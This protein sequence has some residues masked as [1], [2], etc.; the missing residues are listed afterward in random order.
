MGPLHPWSSFHSPVYFFFF[1]H[2]ATLRDIHQKTLFPGAEAMHPDSNHYMQAT[3]AKHACCPEWELGMQLDFFSPLVKCMWGCSNKR[4]WSSGDWSPVL[5]SLT[6]NATC[7]GP[8][9]PDHM[10]GWPLSL[11]HRASPLRKPAQGAGSVTGLMARQRTFVCWVC[12]LI[13][14]RR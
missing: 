5:I 13:P 10:Q 1:P 6:G 4:C 9:P 2:S 7:P 11:E 14:I 8:D 12:V 3:W